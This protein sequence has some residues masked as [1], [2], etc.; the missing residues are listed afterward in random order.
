MTSPGEIIEILSLSHAAIIALGVL[1]LPSS[2][3]KGYIGSIAM[4]E[5]H[6]LIHAWQGK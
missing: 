3:E 5:I 4:S 6:L 2:H 1:N